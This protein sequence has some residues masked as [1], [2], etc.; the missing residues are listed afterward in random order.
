MNQVERRVLELEFDNQ[1]FEHGVKQSI[2]T[3]G[4]FNKS[5][6]SIGEHDGFSKI[7]KSSNDFSLKGIVN[8]VSDAAKEFSNFSN[9]ATSNISDV[10]TQGERFSFRNILN[11]VEGIASKFGFLKK[12]ALSD[13]SDIQLAEE[14]FTVSHMASAIDQLSA[15]FDGLGLAGRR[16]IENIVDS[17]YSKVTSTIGNVWNTIIGKG[18]ARAQAIENAR[19]TLQGL[20]GDEEKVQN[21][22]AAA[23]ESVND[24]AYGFDQAA[25]AAAMFATTGVQDYETML[26]IL[27]GV[28]GVTATVNGDYGRISQVFT[29]I[30]GNGRVMATDLLSLSTNSLNAAGI[31]RDAFNKVLDGSSNLSAGTQEHIRQMVVEGSKSIKDFSGTLEEITEHD[32]REMV[33][34]GWIDFNTF[35]EIMSVT[36]GEHAKKAQTTFTGA[37]ANVRAALARTGAMFFEP[38]IAQNTPIVKF[39]DHLRS[40]IN[41]VNASMKEILPQ[42]VA[43]GIF[44]L[45]NAGSKWI[46]LAVDTVRVFDNLVVPFQSLS[47]I[48]VTIRT[49]FSAVFGGLYEPDMIK[50]LQRLKDFIGTLDITDEQLSGI[51]TVAM[52]FFSALKLVL[53]VIKGVFS[54]VKALMPLVKVILH[55]LGDFVEFLSSIFTGFT[56]F[57]TDKNPF[58]RFASSLSTVIER[59]ANVIDIFGT[60]IETFFGILSSNGGFHPIS[61][62]IQLFSTLKDAISNTHQAI[63]TL[64]DPFKRVIDLVRGIPAE[65]ATSLADTI[66]ERLQQNLIN[67]RLASRMGG[68]ISAIVGGFAGNIEPIDQATEA[69]EGFEEACSDTAES[70]GLVL[71]SFDALSGVLD[72]IKEVFQAIASKLGEWFNGIV[73][74][75]DEAFATGDF[76]KIFRG[77]SGIL[78]V[79]ILAKLRNFAGQLR[80]TLNEIGNSVSTSIS[81]FGEIGTSFKNMM[82]SIG[83]GFKALPTAIG[84]GLR[85][86]LKGVTDGLHDMTSRVSPAQIVAIAAA[87]WILANALVTLKDLNLKQ[88]GTG[89]VGVAGALG[90]MI[91]TLWAFTKFIAV[92]DLK[93]TMTS[94]GGLRGLL[95]GGTKSIQSTP[96]LS[97]ALFIVGLSLAVLIMSDA[98][99]NLKDL[100]LEAV[101]TGLLGLAGIMAA[102]AAFMVV[103]KKAHVLEPSFVNT[104][105]GLIEAKSQFASMFEFI[106]IAAAVRLLADTLILLAAVPIDQML[107]GL[108]G[109]GSIL[110]GLAGFMVAVNGMKFSISGVLMLAT[111]AYVVSMLI[112]PFKTLADMEWEQLKKGMVAYSVI[113]GGLAAAV[114]VMG[115]TSSK[116]TASWEKNKKAISASLTSYLSMSVFIVALAAALFI[117]VEA[118]GNL[119]EVD[120]VAMVNSMI[121][122]TSMLA[123]MVLFTTFLE[124]VN[125]RSFDKTGKGAAF[126]SI[127]VEMIAMSAAIYILA[128]SLGK[129]AELDVNSLV[130]ATLSIAG[131]MATLMV[132]AYAVDGV[133][134]SNIAALAALVT[135]IMPLAMGLAAL[136]AI[137]LK[138]LAIAVGAIAAVFIV[139]G[140]AAYALQPVS[141]IVLALAGALGLIALSITGVVL[142]FATLLAALA[143]LG[144]AVGLYGVVML[145][146]IDD[147]MARLPDLAR[148]IADSVVAFLEE[149]NRM[150]E[151]LKEAFIGLIQTG[152]EAMVESAQIIGEGFLQTLDT[153]LDLLI[154]YMPTI[155]DKLIELGKELIRILEEKLGI[156]FEFGGKNLLSRF[157]DG[158]AEDVGDI[159]D[160]TMNLIIAFIDGL[161]TAIEANHDALYDAI[162]HLVEAIKQA[163]LDFAE[164]F[165]PEA[166]TG[167]FNAFAIA[168]G[169]VTGTTTGF[170]SL[171]VLIG[172]FLGGIPGLFGKTGSDSGTKMAQGIDSKK[173]SVK[174]SSSNLA[175]QAVT[176]VDTAKPGFYTAGQGAGGNYGSGIGSVAST[177]MAKGTEIANSAKSGA[178]SVSLWQ[179]GYDTAA[180][181]GNGINSKFPE[182]VTHVGQ[183]AQSVAKKIRDVLGIGSPSKVTYEYGMFTVLGF[184][185]GMSDTMPVAVQSA[186][187]MAEKS[188]QAIAEAVS[189]SSN[190][191]SGDYQ[192]VITPVV[193]L[194]NVEAASG[195]LN[196]VFSRSGVYSVLGS[197]AQG[198]GQS[199][200]FGNTAD[201]NAYATANGTVI[202][203]T[204]N[205]TNTSPKALS[206]LEIYRKTKSMFAMAKSPEAVVV[207]H[208]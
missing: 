57:L 153:T 61:A 109:L 62:I 100:D 116:F 108:V 36:F 80:T 92:G 39:L 181:Y 63:G 167:L 51:K 29:R 204:F 186:E 161:A 143:S 67:T 81:K 37:M 166:G 4:Q 94:S 125:T 58:E 160:S 107:M 169:L 121:V 189:E 2:D 103:L 139:L 191:L 159:I 148:S 176:G 179:T 178:G 152:V 97:M 135:V 77:L 47:D 106:V 206:S 75:L 119:A 180:G 69:V 23:Q 177:V 132:A 55:Y 145:T 141:G 188:M 155:V 117:I 42:T 9:A 199:T 14:R 146:F 99:V 164:R 64:S 74:M 34:K 104:S 198:I 124:Y 31:M 123:F 78:V 54:I 122:L 86:G 43:D 112:A 201:A 193:D 60:S 205:Q 13:L 151:P 207:Y 22:L 174:S 208:A 76:S 3:I 197:N 56:N 84:E 8:A 194:S 172:G 44:A 184:S 173:G 126:L 175:A 85:D 33:S 68:Q 89:L 6:E 27:K 91:A 129:L 195:K 102:L 21:L 170:G 192:P 71:P 182:V 10:E 35:S 138:S 20:L 147:L 82:G 101:S 70:V 183:Y 73:N 5:L 154:E 136:S 59:V 157:I 190:M 28:A 72:K 187:S 110:I 140:V 150:R 134:A 131:V 32:I 52:G 115:T 16:V 120:S 26:S 30:A 130:A 105:K 15:K 95:S 142:A 202:N 96:F 11:G 65:R 24:T 111:I 196:S 165:M 90:L 18:Y 38:L 25:G 66:A 49:A 19:F 128:E 203:Q 41:A 185:N 200:K 171:P 144:T 137:P 158:L 12:G 133:K 118:I 163:I 1:N 40:L 162:E 17:A 98:L 50:T 93:T 114:K 7:E 46:S 156:E 88:I 79:G 45:A 87:V 53:T 127:A 83:E 168:A 149:L 113:V 48:M